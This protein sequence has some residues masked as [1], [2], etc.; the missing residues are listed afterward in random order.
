M[1]QNY[2]RNQTLLTLISYLSWLIIGVMV[3]GLWVTASAGHREFMVTTSMG[4]QWAPWGMHGQGRSLV[5]ERGRLL[6]IKY[7]LTHWDLGTGH[8]ISWIWILRIYFYESKRFTNENAW[9]LFLMLLHDDV[10]K[11]KHFSHYWPFMRGIHR[12]QLN[13]PRKGQWR[14]VLVFS[15]ICV[16]INGWVNNREAGDLRCFRAPYDVTVMIND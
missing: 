2:N 16:W 7:M 6:S 13:S 11:W 8:V 1:Y 10:I 15:L 9:T 14:G 4:K 5:P 12:S 3:P